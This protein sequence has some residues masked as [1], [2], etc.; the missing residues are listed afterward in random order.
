MRRSLAEGAAAL[1][2]S[3]RSTMS[4]PGAITRGEISHQPDLWPDTVRRVRGAAIPPIG[5]DERPM[6]TGAGSSAYAAMAIAAA[7]PGARAVPT[8]DLLLDARSGGVP[9]LPRD[10]LL[11][12][13]ARSGDSPESVGVVEVIQRVRPDVRHLALMCNERGRLA[14]TNG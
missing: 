6:I 12:S 13:I 3:Q 5:A 14:H 2:Y 7:W 8:T 10:G 4:A 9:E 11:I 1:Q